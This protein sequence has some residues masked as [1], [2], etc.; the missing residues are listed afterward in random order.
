MKPLALGAHTFGFAWECGAEQAMEQLAK[1]SK[2]GGR[3]PVTAVFDPILMMAPRASF[4]N[5]S[6]KCAML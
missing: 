3:D 4:K 6:V 1:Y 5:G 2:V